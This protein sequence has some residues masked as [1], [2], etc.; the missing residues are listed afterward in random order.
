M[1]PNIKL[2][3][4]IDGKTYNTETATYLAGY[5]GDDGPFEYG[6]HLYQTRFGAFFLV[7]YVDGGGEEDYQKIIPRTPEQAREW[8]EEKQSYRVDV[9]EQLFGE[10]PEAGSGEVKYTLRMPE[11]LRDRLAERAKANG[12]SLNAWMIRCLESCT[13]DASADTSEPREIPPMGN[14][15]GSNRDGW[16]VGGK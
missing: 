15:V 14:M 3:R 5:D 16:K 12:Q 11:T 13:Q 9:I 1:A 6:E 4:I 7:S 8:L 2:K 10:M